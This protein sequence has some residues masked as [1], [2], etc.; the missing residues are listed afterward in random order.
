MLKLQLS[1]HPRLVKLA[2]PGY[3][4]CVCNYADC[5]IFGV[6]DIL[7]AVMVGA[8]TR[9]CSLDWKKALQGA[10]QAAYHSSAVQDCMIWLGM[11]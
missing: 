8:A 10:L 7:W 1:P 3:V 5:M 6:H 11:P 9:Q 2:L 4:I